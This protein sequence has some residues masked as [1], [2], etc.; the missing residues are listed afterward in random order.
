VKTLSFLFD[1]LMAY[2]VYRIVR[3]D[4]RVAPGLPLFAAA[5]VV[6]LPTVLINSSL[7]GQADSLYGCAIVACLY[8]MILDRPLS[9][10]IAFGVAFSFKLQS[11]FFAPVLLGYLWKE[12]E[13]R[14]ALLVPGIFMLSLIPAW[15]GGAPFANLLLIYVHQTKEYSGLNE[16]SPSAFAFTEYRH[17]PP[18][19]ETALFWLGIAAAA[20]CALLVALAVSRTGRNDRRGLLLISMTCVV[21]LPYLLPRMHERYFYLSDVL[22]TV[23]AFH[24]P[25]RWYIPAIFVISSLMAYMRVLSSRVSVFAPFT[26]DIRVTALLLGLGIAATIMPELLHGN[27][28]RL[29]LAHVRAGSSREGHTVDSD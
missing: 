1:I 12:R 29:T 5:T 21:L 13:W 6:S 20:T 3:D 10:S 27:R 16:S 25:R 18:T 2:F 24:N 26:V 23:Y 19:L 8:F 11:I 14:G 9:S 17:I 28:F 22:S 15:L 7:W 4:E